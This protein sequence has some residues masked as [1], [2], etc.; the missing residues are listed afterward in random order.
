MSETE[1][2]QYER[3]E[4]KRLYRSRTNKVVSGVAGGIGE[5]FGVDPTIVR[6]IWILSV[7]LGGSGIIA[8][9]A[10]AIVIPLQPDS[11]SLQ[12]T[13]Q[14]VSQPVNA[15]V[16]PE[17]TAEI[18]PIIGAVL[19]GIGVWFL[20]KNLGIVPSWFFSYIDFLKRAF[21]PGILIAAGVLIILGVGKGSFNLTVK[22][23][24]LYRSR[25][26]RRIAGVAGGLAKY[27]GADPTL[28]R[29]IFL[30]LLLLGSFPIVL[31]AY[32]VAA[33]VIP[34]EANV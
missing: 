16:R 13:D 30:A 12:S 27:Y 15:G 21:W 26:D 22:G 7:L 25:T 1:T 11:G 32:I 31:I 18:G 3:R 8:Y 17:S 10:A 33:I 24:T 14:S 9:I 6:L 29:F 20:L 5:Y 28:V 34:E 2:A 19:I 23:K 4:P